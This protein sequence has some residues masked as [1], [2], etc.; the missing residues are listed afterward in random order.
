MDIRSTRDRYFMPFAGGASFFLLAPLT[1]PSKDGGDG[2]EKSDLTSAAYSEWRDRGPELVFAAMLLLV[3][4]FA[5]SLTA[6]ARI[7]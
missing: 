5:L 7:P 3:V 2:L 4:G 6:W 1:S